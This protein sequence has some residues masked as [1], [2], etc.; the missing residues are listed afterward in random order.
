MNLTIK[1]TT[2]SPENS[3]SP[4][5]VEALY[6]LTKPDPMTGLPSADAV[7]V[8]R[9]QVPAAYEDSV[10]FLNTQFS[11]AN[12]D[13]GSD[14]Q[15]TVLDNN[16]YIRF[17]DPNLLNWLISKNVLVDGDAITISQ[18]GTITFSGHEFF[19][20]SGVL[21][22]DEYKYFTKMN[23]GRADGL[24][25]AC[26]LESIDLTNAESVSWLQYGWAPNLKYFNGRDSEEGSLNLPNL[27]TINSTNGFEG[28]TGIKKLLSLGICT[29]LGGS[30]FAGCSNLTTIHQ[31]VCNQLTTIKGNDFKN[32]P[33][34]NFIQNDETVTHV[35]S[36]PNLITLEG[37]AFARDKT[38]TTS[39]TEIASLGV[40]SVIGEYAFKNCTNL[41]TVN[42]PNTI[43]EI[44]TGAF[45]GTAWLAAQSDAIIING[46]ALYK[47]KG[48]T[49]GN[50]SVPYSVISITGEAFDGNTTLTGLSIPSN[51]FKIGNGV[52][53]GCTNLVSITVDA[54][55]ATYDSRD[56]CNAIIE[57]S[58]NKLI[59]GCSATSIPNTCM[60][61]Q[62]YAFSGFTLNNLS[63][64]TT[65]GFSLGS[66]VFD[67]AKLT[68][69]L[70]IPGNVTLSTRS[71]DDTKNSVINSLVLGEGIT[72]IPGYC[73]RL[74]KV[75]G[76]VE[77]PST[78]TDMSAYECLAI[79]MNS[80]YTV[81]FKSS[82]PPTFHSSNFPFDMTLRSGT[83]DCTKCYVPSGSKSA[84]KAAFLAINVSGD[85]HTDA[86]MD[87][88]IEEYSV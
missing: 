37:S 32:C 1:Q 19:K 88:W 35:L 6:Q 20:N 57:T 48:N 31:N 86:F 4:N 39:F 72:T 41:L 59:A 24:L 66:Y 38:N 17:E 25:R 11:A 60:S 79:Y 22:F 28:D 18:A 80:N 82:V 2:G 78:L 21:S 49:G 73:F 77:F 43:S 87:D 10:S 52:T 16:Y 46:K 5:L 56:N 45:E 33:I 34:A 69:N 23:K 84:Y 70:V 30:T 26:S 54:N 47:H 71:F 63:L 14:F 75:I 58:T 62:R 40:V 13:N 12:S 65:Q 85:W 27:K 36:L 67:G 83:R 74:V 44:G 53:K 61:I 8:G 42:F 29:V 50:Y 81:K 76:T 9:I 64:P 15:V 68:G 51:V 7:L 55:N 3:S